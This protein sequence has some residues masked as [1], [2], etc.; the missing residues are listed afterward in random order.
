MR[1]E[2]AKNHK[3]III[4]LDNRNIEIH[5]LWLRERVNNS[6]FL[7]RATGQRLYDVQL[8]LQVTDRTIWDELR[9]QGEISASNIVITFDKNDTADTD[10]ITLTL[11][12]Y[13]VQTV[14]IPFPDDKGMLDVALTL[15]ARTLHE[16]K[17]HGKWIIQG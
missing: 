12:D 15:S 17:Y 11:K 16:C 3:K 9:K 10:K 1:I 2:I 5:P 14:D 4:F 7:D 6:E 13:I 8:N